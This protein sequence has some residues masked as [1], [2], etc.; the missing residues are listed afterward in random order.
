MSFLSQLLEHEDAPSFNYSCG[1][2]LAS[3]DLAEL[4]RYA[5][6]L[7]VGRPRLNEVPP[8]WLEGLA[9]SCGRRIPHYRRLGGYAGDFTGL[10]LLNRADLRAAPEDFIDPGLDRSRLMVYTTSGTTASELWVPAD[11]LTAAK[12]LPLLEHLLARFGVRF[13]R[14][15][16]QV[17]MASVGFQKE[18][19][20]YATQAAYLRGSGFLKLN[21]DPADWPDP[22]SPR[23]YLSHFKPPV[24]NGDP[25]SLQKLELDYRPE[26]LIS[27]AMHL[28]EG[29]KSQLEAKF[30]CP[31][32]DLYSMTE[33][34]MLAVRSGAFWEPL[35]PDMYLELVDSTGTPVVPG[36]RGELVVSSGRNPFQPLLR[37]RTGDYAV[38]EKDGTFSHFEGRSPVVFQDSEGGLINNIDVTRALRDLP[39]AQFSL[40]Q[41]Q[42]LSLTMTIWGQVDKEEVASRL[43][44]LF[45]ETEFR[46]TVSGEVPPGKAIRYSRDL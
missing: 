36:E 11:P 32:I 38:L 21:L 10:P 12:A 34:R 26:A 37:Y 3:T 14:G 28:Q 13:R 46:V 7:E 29:L 20:T 27:T 19:L 39:L 5:A 22:G 23:R 45:K 24:V 30:E 33:A 1:D 15:P 17:F 44:R 25:L 40:H 35:A 16:G 41:N 9:A 31:V 6:Q 4:H 18:T 2:H 8:P 42:D 43:E